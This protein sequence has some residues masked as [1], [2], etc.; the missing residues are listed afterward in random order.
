[1]SD[2]GERGAMLRGVNPK[3]VIADDAQAACFTAPRM[4][5]GTP[6]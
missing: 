1:M 2:E 4:K 3:H 6:R 5:H